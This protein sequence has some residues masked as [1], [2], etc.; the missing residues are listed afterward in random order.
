MAE[1]NLSI[2]ILEV[3]KS[4]SALWDQFV[5]NSPQGTFFHTT[6]WADV[7]S[8]TFGRSYNIVF[9]IKNEQTV[10]GMIFFQH[11]KFVWN[12]ITPTAFF[13]YCAPIFYRPVNEKPQKSI[14]NQ[15][16]ITASFESYLREH[17]DYWILDV[18][19]DSKDVR[20]FLWK[21]ATIEP[22]YSY[23]VSLKS[24]D[25]LYD[26]YNQSVRKKLKQAKEQNALIIESRDPLKLADLVSRSYRRHGMKPHVSED[27]LN[28]FLNKVMELKQAKLYYLE[29]NGI[30][31]AGRLVIIDR[32]CG[33]DL[34]AGSDDQKGFGSTYLMTS[35]LEKY[36]GE[37]KRFDF[38]GA[39]HPQIEQ[40]KRGFGG[41]LTQGFRITNK[42]KIPL[43]W[44]IRFHRYH[45]QKERVI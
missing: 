44:I 28:I 29:L 10:G 13:P 2:E 4:D 45:T 25:E 5:E 23:V 24:K 11:K 37:I 8:S 35:I 40:F 43:S 36:I 26:N 22:Q 39:N 9:C 42:T 3:Q 18:P 19:S 6:A 1:S 16:T 17:Y 27:H 12:M 14:H 38:L 30:I 7:I 41:E 21:G 33:Y 34:L 20:S 32:L 15:L 31:T